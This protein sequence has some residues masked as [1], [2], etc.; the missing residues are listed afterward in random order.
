[1]LGPS[2]ATLLA[3]WV[4]FGGGRFLWRV[5]P[6]V[7]GAV[8]YLQCI[9]LLRGEWQGLTIGQLGVVGVLLLVARVVGFELVCCKN[10]PTVPRR[11]QFTIRDMLTWMTALAVILGALH[12][13][14]E[15][16]FPRFSIEGAIAVFG[17]FQLVA[18]ASI[19][20]S[21]CNGWL[22]VRLPLLPLTI[23]LSAVVLASRGIGGPVWYLSLLLGLTRR[24]DHGIA[25]ARSICRI[26]PDM[27]VAIR[28]ERPR[29]RSHR[30]IPALGR[31]TA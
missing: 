11:F 15:R 17:T 6:I 22:L 7:V 21:L 5:L 1:M 2:Q 26:P 8:V 28:P 14:P 3:F 24:M 18:V 20:L 19:V 13:M 12:Y 31:I 9:A 4:A 27:A 16:W 23:G 30:P 29:W 25:P 10:P